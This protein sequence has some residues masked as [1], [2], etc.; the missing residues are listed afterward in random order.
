M[1]DE[2][3]RFSPQFDEANQETIACDTVLLAVGQSPN[4]G[5]LSDGGADV[6]QG[7]P[8]WPK[9]DKSTL[10]T[11]VPGVFVAGDLWRTARDC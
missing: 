6:E 5:F 2:N 7:R 11:T 1:Y 8:G 4:V 9:V 3:R 10:A